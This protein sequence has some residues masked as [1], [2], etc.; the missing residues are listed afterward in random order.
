MTWQV[1][2]QVTRTLT[3]RMC[4]RGGSARPVLQ[5]PGEDGAWRAYGALVR[6]GSLDVG[7][8]GRVRA[9]RTSVLRR[10]FNSGFVRLSSTRW[11]VQKHV[12]RTLIFE[13]G[14]NTLF[15]KN[16]LWYQLLGNFQNSNTHKFTWFGNLP[17]PRSYWFVL[18]KITNNTNKRGGDQT[19]ST[20]LYSLKLSLFFSV[21]S[22]LCV[23]LLFF[24][25]SSLCQHLY[26]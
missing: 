7:A 6:V 12:W 22:T 3:V 24:N 19:L 21:L 23:S 11:Y 5:N 20:Q 16:K 1:T 9:C 14:S 4:W 26:L 13:F 8:C 25:I 2:C 17:T 18:M 15:V 10:V